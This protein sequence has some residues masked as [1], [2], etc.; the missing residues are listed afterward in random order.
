M[1]QNNNPKLHE[2][3]VMV[4]KGWERLQQSVEN[5]FTKNLEIKL[6]KKN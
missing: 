1:K 4:C 6:S 3:H 5:C 2:V